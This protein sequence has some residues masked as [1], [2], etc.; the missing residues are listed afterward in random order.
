VF[1]RCA[2]VVSLHPFVCS[3]TALTAALSP[4]MQF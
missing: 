3:E 2:E 1:S 4:V